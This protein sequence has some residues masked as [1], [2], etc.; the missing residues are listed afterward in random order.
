MKVLFLDID[1]V[2][3]SEQSAVYYHRLWEANKPRDCPKEE[4]ELCPIAISNLRFIA[5]NCPDLKIVITSVWRLGEK[6]ERFQKIFKNVGL[7]PDLLIGMT[8]GTYNAYRGAEIQD[9]LN[10]HGSKVESF[11][12]VDDDDD[13]AHLADKLV[14]T[15]WTLG[16]TIL[17]AK[18]ILDMLDPDWKP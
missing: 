16:L 14:Q 4:D 12:I 18:K 1:G 6:L 13:M 5:E 15:H 8:P 9:W 3:N 7:D 11:A 2:L 10:K 17:D